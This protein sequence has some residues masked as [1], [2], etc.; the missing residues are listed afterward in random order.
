MLSA[1]GREL[2]TTEKGRCYQA[3]QKSKLYKQ[4]LKKLRSRGSLLLE[5]VEQE[6]K[7]QVIRKDFDVWKHDYVDFV[8]T[9]E[10]ICSLMEGEE[11][12]NL[13]HDKNLTEVN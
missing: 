6:E 8:Q 10:V 12:E 7:P 9:Y 1:K 4:L 2:R 5:S 11:R 13:D 3:A